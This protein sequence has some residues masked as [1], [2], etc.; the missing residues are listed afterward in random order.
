MGKDKRKVFRPLFNTQ[1]LQDV[2]SAFVLGYQVYAQ[3]SDSGLLPP[4]LERTQQLTGRKVKTLRGDGIYASLKDLRS[5]KENVVVLYA[6]VE[7]GS[8]GDQPAGGQQEAGKG[9]AAGGKGGRG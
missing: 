5:C 9:G 6:P 8:V 7:R 4:M 1:I 3:V 2:A